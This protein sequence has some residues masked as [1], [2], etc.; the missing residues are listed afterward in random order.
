MNKLNKQQR[1]R[2]DHQH[3]DKLTKQH[4]DNTAIVVSHLGYHLILEHQGRILSADWR[5]HS[6]DIACNDRVLIRTTHDEH[7][8]VEAVLPRAHAFC[9]WQGRKSKVIAA[10]LQQ[11]LIVIAVEPDWQENFIDRHLIAAQEAGISSAIL[12]NKT[13]LLEPHNIHIIN[14]RLAPYH[15]LHIP[16]YRASLGHAAAPTD[17]CQWLQ[18][19]QTL[20]CGQSGVGK[21]SLIRSLKPDTDIWIQAISAVTGHGR[22]TTTNL[23]RY[24]LDDET[25]LIDTPG[26][27]GFALNHLG[28]DAIINGFPDIQPYAASCRFSDCDHQTAP[29]CAVLAALEKGE[30]ATAR[31]HSLLQLLNEQI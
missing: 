6:S 29:D 26:V 15:K 17:L 18:G 14:E 22:H 1:R 11:V 21:S 12:L 25:A 19:K 7:A 16:V 20:L 4:A 31:Y 23:R 27:R 30:I 24:P 2:I 10:N 3:A 28:R 9:K 5:K 13:D 8:V